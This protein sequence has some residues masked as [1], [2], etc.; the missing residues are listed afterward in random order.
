MEFGTWFLLSPMTEPVDT[1]FKAYFLKSSG[2]VIMAAEITIE[3]Q[4]LLEKVAGID[5]SDHKPGDYVVSDMAGG[6]IVVPGGPFRRNTT[7]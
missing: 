7:E 2:E 5:L 3:H 1:L 4:E 6:H